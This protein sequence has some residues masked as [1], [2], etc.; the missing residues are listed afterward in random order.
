MAAQ[1]ENGA[2][3]VHWSTSGGQSGVCQID[4]NGQITAW[5]VGEHR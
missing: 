2:R 3:S 1:N 5:T 4:G